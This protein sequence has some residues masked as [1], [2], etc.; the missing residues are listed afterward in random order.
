MR[1]IRGREVALTVFTGK[2]LC[3]REL[4][5]CNPTVSKGPAALTVRVTLEF[6]FPDDDYSVT[7]MLVAVRIW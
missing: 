4:T 1:G 2:S 5:Q 6:S 3:M 7:V